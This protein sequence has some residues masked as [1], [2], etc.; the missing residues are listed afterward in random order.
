LQ[1]ELN[2]EKLQQSS[3][4]FGNLAIVFGQ[5]N[6]R[7]GQIGK[8]FAVTQALINTY[9]S[10]TKAFDA[11]AD[12]PVVGPALGAA[13]AAAAIAAG[14]ANVAKIEGF[15]TGGYTGN[16]GTSDVAGVVHGQE[17]VMTAD[18]TKQYRPILDA[19]HDGSFNADSLASRYGYQSSMSNF[20]SDSR[21][22]TPQVQTVA[23]KA[24]STTIHVHNHG[25]E[26]AM[27][28]FLKSEK[29]GTHIVNQIS[30]NSNKVSRIVQNG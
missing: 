14:L 13:A 24:S 4:F 6:T 10:A 8:A 21:P 30:R 20:L 29:G 3:D 26:E 27:I 18:K 1:K 17:F 25:S 7:L 16:T 12:I 11:L 22:V 23:N 9:S 15:E 5:G 2:D 19:M 28:D